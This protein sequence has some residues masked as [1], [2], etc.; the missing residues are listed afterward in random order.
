[1]AARANTGESGTRVVSRL[2]SRVSDWHAS[3][4]I[5]AIPSKVTHLKIQGR[6]R[7]KKKKESIECFFPAKKKRKK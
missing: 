2:K 1:M 7:K 5:E 4:A 6:E 3:A